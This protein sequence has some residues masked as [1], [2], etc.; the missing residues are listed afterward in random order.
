MGRKVHPIGF[1]IGIIKDWRT[2][3]YA[4]G[5]QYTKLLEEDRQIRRRIYEMNPNAAISYIEIER[6]PNEVTVTIHSARPGIL[7]G[8]RGQNVNALRNELQQLTDKRVKVDVREVENP[9]L[10]ARLV[11]QNLAEQL[12]R[13]VSY[14]RAMKRAVE[15]AIQAG[16][17][18]AMVTCGGRL[19]GAEMARRETVREG[20][21]PRHTLRADIDY[22]Q[23]EALTTFGRIGVK[24]WIYLGDVLPEKAAAEQAAAEG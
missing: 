15:R 1:R 8:R 16:A 5:S 3:W 6:Y 14:K 20:R 18:G 19:A 17:K 12:E 10:D 4:E 21:V 22:G 9:D 23:A 7:I 2:R 24:V 13:R 11:A